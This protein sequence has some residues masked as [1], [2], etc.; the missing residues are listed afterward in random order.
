M[1]VVVT[2]RVDVY[3]SKDQYLG[4]LSREGVRLEAAPRVGE[5]IALTAFGLPLGGPVDLEPVHSVEHHPSGQSLAVVVRRH[6]Q[7]E[8]AFAEQVSAA[9]AEWKP[10][11]AF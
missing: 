7:G 8:A 2:V 11:E 3:D 1:S 10:F 4:S 9:E 5:K 6:A